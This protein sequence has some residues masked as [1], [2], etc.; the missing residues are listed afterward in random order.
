ML[1]FSSASFGAYFAHT[2][3]APPHGPAVVVLAV[4]MALGIEC[5]KPFAVE[6]VFIAFAGSP[7][8]LDHEDGSPLECRALHEV[9][10]SA[11]KRDCRTYLCP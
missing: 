8:F 4:A 1:V 10:L 2:Q 6:G 3:A 9:A 11:A 7:S 5:A